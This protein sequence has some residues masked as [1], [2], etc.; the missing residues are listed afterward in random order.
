MK[1]LAV[2]DEESEYL[3]DYKKQKF[4]GIDLILSC[5]DLEAEYLSFLATVSS[6][7]VLY[8]MGNHDDKYIVKAPEGC[9]CIEN[10]IYVYQGVRIL[11]LGGSM[12]YNNG[13]NQYTEKEMLYRIR[14]M[15]LKLLKN[16]GFDILVTHSPAYGLN[17]GKDLPHRGFQVFHNMLSQYQPRFFVHGHAHLNYG[18]EYKRHMQHG[19]THVI[20]AY[21][22]YIFEY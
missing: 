5:G 4:D 12:R 2:S 15:K 9:I 14:K 8:V 10:K 19:N 20:N 13:V 6:V 16:R 11:G 3:W 17:D 21:E 18:R 1:I 7:P 22:R